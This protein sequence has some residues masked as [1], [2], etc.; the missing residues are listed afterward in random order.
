[1]IYVGCCGFC[2]ARQR[3]YL[4]FDVVELQDT[5][6]NPPELDKLKKLAEEAP[7]DFVFAMKA[8]QAITHPLDSP[9]WKKAKV[10]P[11][12]NLA[13][14]YGFLR[15]TKE[16]FEAWESVVE[17]A[18][19]LEAEV[20]VIQTPPSFGYSEEYY[21]N[22]VEFFSATNTSNFVIGWEPRGTWL[23]NLDKVADIVSRFKNVIHIVDPFK[24]LP[25]VCK[26]VTYFRLHGIGKGE[27]NYRYKYTDEDLQNLLDIV[28]KILS[29]SNNVYAMFNNVYMAQDAQRFRELIKKA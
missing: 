7:P 1:M 3:Y 2:M 28:R 6:Y 9:T 27:V 19:T 26:E 23:Q 25:T 11:D 17:A 20:I 21:R 16:V 15:P 14:R 8:W 22:A 18:K 5:F 12:K 29:K 24:A 13:D 4:A 10:V